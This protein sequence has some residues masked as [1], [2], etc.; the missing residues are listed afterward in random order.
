M[1]KIYRNG[2]QL[3]N[4]ILNAPYSD[5]IDDELDK[6]NFQIKS[7]SRL[8]FYKNDKITYI[9]SQ[10][11]SDVE[12]NVIQ[13]T[14]CLFDYVET[15]DGEYWLY[16]LTCLSPTKLLEN[17]IVNGMA[18]THSNWT[19]LQ[20][21]ER[22][23]LKINKQ[24][25][26]EATYPIE[27]K[28]T[29]SVT[30]DKY[31]LNLKQGSDF[32]WSGQQ[33]AREILQDICDK[34]DM[35]LVATDYEVYANAHFYIKEITLDV[36]PREKGGTRLLETNSSIEGGGLDAYKTIIKGLSIH[37]NSEFTN[38][39]IVS[40]MKN[41]IAKDNVQQTYMPARN[42]DL[43]IDNSADWHIITQEP[44]YSLNKV[45]VMCAF[46]GFSLEYPTNDT[47]SVRAVQC[48]F[49]ID[50][51][52][53]ILEKDV[54]DTMSISDQAKHLYFKRGESGIYGLYK[55]YKSGLT[56]LI[57]DYALY[58]ILYDILLTN[59]T[60]FMETFDLGDYLKSYLE[61]ANAPLL[62]WNQSQ[63]KWDVFPTTYVDENGITRNY[64]DTIQ[65]DS[66]NGMPVA[67][68]SLHYTTDDLKQCLFSVNYQP[69]C[70]SV[71]KIGKGEQIK[72]R[73]FN[74][75]VLKNQSDRTIDASKYYDSQRALIKRLGNDEMSL[76]C[77]F[78]GVRLWSL[79][80]SMLIQNDKWTLTKRE[81]ENY[82]NDK[83]KARLTFSNKYNASN[84]AI[85]VNRDKRLYGIPLNNYVDRYILINVDTAY[86]YTKLLVYSYDDFTLN[87]DESTS[88]SQIGYTILDLIRIGN[89]EIID[90]VARCKDNYAVDIER[91]KYS[92][93]IVNVNLRYCM[94]NGEMEDI[95]LKLLTDSQY[96]QLA[97]S[98]YSRLPFLPTTTINVGIDKTLEDIYK[99]KME[100]LIF[101]IKGYN[102]N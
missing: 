20:Q 82:G 3:T 32:L 70:D 102:P 31:I 21:L 26:C 47:P 48:G 92:S 60:A 12:T 98:D 56:G 89:D 16:Q 36:I 72:A 78:D 77:I 55:K 75:S 74:L 6:A 80:D 10:N 45:Y 86:D 42:T 40:L 96:N 101:V 9:V 38:G 15:L 91:T 81:I 76:D 68:S 94:T 95:H 50:I 97:I 44:I 2:T 84:S 7:A 52:N 54:F 5:T 11:I 51:T 28:L 66:S 33:T 64:I 1:V 58:N 85:N 43:T 24:F 23:I 79:G 34:A 73:S 35:L 61:R 41:G 29:T 39:S 13:K 37:R 83:I 63:T 49:P 30:S 90:K 100:R 69:Y 25:I 71:V 14:F 67:W 19:L 93:T 22:T 27:L 59:R 53:Y 57:S 46:S 87:Q 4:F 8:T 99:D 62:K 65:V 17:I 18:E 88:D